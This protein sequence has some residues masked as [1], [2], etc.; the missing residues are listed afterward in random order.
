MSFN[1]FILGG[2]GGGV[3]SGPEELTGFRSFALGSPQCFTNQI[4]FYAPGN[5][6]Y[7]FQRFIPYFTAPRSG[8]QAVLTLQRA[9]DLGRT[10]VVNWSVVDGCTNASVGCS[11]TNG[12]VTFSVG[13]TLNQFVISVS[14]QA[15]EHGVVS[16]TVALSS[17]NANV[18]VPAPHADVLFYDDSYLTVQWSGTSNAPAGYAR[19]DVLGFSPTGREFYR[20]Q[21]TANS[22][23]ANWSDV[24]NALTAMFS[25][26]NLEFDWE[27]AIPT[28]KIGPGFYR[29]V[30]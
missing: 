3:P 18:T 9:G 4:S 24:T 15:V 13:Q 17:T 29:G 20:L 30:K 16:L 1:N 21:R 26:H 19:F 7:L 8:P 6:P 23:P 2:C 11:P 28:N 27:F 5:D 25:G 14:P 10:D 22:S 12:L